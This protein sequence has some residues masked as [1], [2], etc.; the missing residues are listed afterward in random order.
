MALSNHTPTRCAATLADFLAIPATARFPEI[1]DGE[2]RNKATPSRKHAHA[3]RKLGALLDPYAEKAG[4][5]A[6]A[7]RRGAARGAVF[8]AGD[9]RGCFVWSLSIPV[10]VSDF[11]IH[12]GRCQRGSTGASKL[13][14]IGC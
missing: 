5:D 9:R 1:L 13:L 11:L 14:I 6:G 3:Q 4:R 2:L 8:A 10:S 7:A 12:G